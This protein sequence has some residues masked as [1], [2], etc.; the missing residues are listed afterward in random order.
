MIMK[1]S[2]YMR[3]FQKT[4]AH[5]KSYDGQTKWMYFPIITYW[6]YISDKVSADIKKE[7]DSKPVYNNFF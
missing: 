5:V 4:K 3:C 2:Y 7:L 6:K 1:L